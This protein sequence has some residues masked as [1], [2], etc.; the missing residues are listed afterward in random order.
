MMMAIPIIQINELL[1]LLRASLV[2]SAAFSLVTPV[3]ATKV[4][5]KIAIAPMGMAL[6]MMPA[7]MPTNNAKRCHASGD[8]PC[9]T[10]MTN[11]IISVSASAT[12]AGIG[13]KPMLSLLV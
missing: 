13:L 4:M 5:P 1:R 10:G 2:A 11:Q 7:M 6:P 8:T 3:S 9:G 12:A